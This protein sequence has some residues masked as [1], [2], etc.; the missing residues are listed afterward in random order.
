[1]VVYPLIGVASKT[2]LNTP[3]ANSSPLIP[4]LENTKMAI[5]QYQ[6]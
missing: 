3:A 5:L 1:M 6:I 4:S 2:T